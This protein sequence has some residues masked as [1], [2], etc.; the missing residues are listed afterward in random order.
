MTKKKKDFFFHFFLWLF[1]FMLNKRGNFF[2]IACDFVL[3]KQIKSESNQYQQKHGLQLYLIS[4]PQFLS[5]FIFLA[6]HVHSSWCQ[7]WQPW[8]ILQARPLIS[9]PKHS[10]KPYSHPQ[11]L[12]FLSMPSTLFHFQG[13]WKSQSQ[14]FSTCAE[15][16]QT[17]I[18]QNSQNPLDPITYSLSFTFL[19]Q[20]LFAEQPLITKADLWHLPQKHS[21]LKISLLQQELL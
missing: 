19:L 1:L 7:C 6:S 10:A 15:A 14:N 18:Q 5:Q 11:Q 17:L 16:D 21:F 20:L 2:L 13:L 8:L 3:S 4:W 9:N 12:N